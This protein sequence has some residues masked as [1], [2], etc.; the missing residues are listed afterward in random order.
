MY[1]KHTGCIFVPLS[2][3]HTITAQ[4]LTNWLCKEKA[5]T[6][7]PMSSPR[8]THWVQSPLIGQRNQDWFSPVMSSRLRANLISLLWSMHLCHQG[9]II[10]QF[11][12]LF[13]WPQ[14]IKNIHKGK[15]KHFASSNSHTLETIWQFFNKSD[16][17]TNF[18]SCLDNWMQRWKH[19]HFIHTDTIC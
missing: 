1:T 17:I 14:I 9:E 18:M 12:I 4:S 6:F 19:W 11:L 8:W 13:P 5:I 15:T 10:Q 3:L 2:T 16:E 7:V